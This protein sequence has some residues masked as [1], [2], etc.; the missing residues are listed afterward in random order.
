VEINFTAGY[1]ALASAVPERLKLAIKILTAHY[2][3]N[4]EALSTLDL[5]EV[6]L[7]VATL[8]ADFR[9][10]NQDGGRAPVN[11]E[12]AGAIR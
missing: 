2:F 8:I 11:Q 3:E 4:R 12:C 10:W 9:A 1:G 6:P 7:S 5:K